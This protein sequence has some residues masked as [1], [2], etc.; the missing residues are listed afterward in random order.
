MK[1]ALPAGAA[2]LAF[3]L[4]SACNR[5]EKAPS[6]QE[7]RQQA[8]NAPIPV[9]VAAVQQKDV[10]VFLTGLG[11][12]TAYNTVTV[13][14]RVDGAIVKINFTEGQHVN[15]GDLLAEI[16]PRPYQV[17]LDQAQANLAR[18]EALLNTSKLNLTRNEQLTKAGVVAVQALDTQRA[19]T[20]QYEGTVQG[21]QA[22]IASAKLNLTYSKI[23]APIS[24]RVGLRLVDVGNIVHASDAN[25]ICTITQLKPIAVIFTLPEDNVNEVRARMKQ[26]ALLAD[27]YTR[28]DRTVIESGKLETIDNQID[29]TTGTVKLKAVFDNK[30]EQLWPNEFV[31]I[32]LRLNTDKN[33]I[34]I[35]SSAIQRGPQGTFVYLVGQN[36]TV[37]V[38]NIQIKLSQGLTSVVGSGLQ[39]GER[40]VTDGQERLQV[41]AKVQPQAPQK[42]GQNDQGPS[43]QAIGSGPGA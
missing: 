32:H 36:N 13:K 38:R 21:D 14:S 20:G 11:A 9:G 5:G 33:A 31:N 42:N 8:R 28:D 40:I 19:E 4:L 35:P 10:Q 1:K 30:N 6:A 3:C 34:V 18:D 15:K 26:G 7:Q 16:D 17:A 23:T 24:G 29:A 27:A 37:Q 22:S 41:D 12:V 39:P 43:S 2:L 25:G